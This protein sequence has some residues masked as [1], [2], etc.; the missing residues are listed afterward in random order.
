MPVIPVMQEAQLGGSQS[1]LAWTSMQDYI[2]KSLE[3]LM[4][5]LES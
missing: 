1:R 3:L 2:K 4:E 5:W